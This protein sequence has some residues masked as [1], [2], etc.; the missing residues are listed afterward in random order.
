[1]T[2]MRGRRLTT[3]AVAG[4]LL[5]VAVVASAAATSSRDLAVA[6][7]QTLQTQIETLREIRI[8]R[9]ILLNKWIHHAEARLATLTAP[10]AARTLDQTGVRNQ[11]A[12]SR[13]AIKE[14]ASRKAALVEATRAR[15]A[16]LQSERQALAD[17]VATYGIF[18]ACPV[19][20]EHTVADNFGATVRLP[21]VP[22][23]VHQ[24][25]DIS[26]PSGTPIV[27]PFDGNAV[28]GR[29]EL[30]GLSVNVY[31]ELGHVYNAH[32]ASYGALGS[33]KAGDV[34]GYVG[35][36]GDATGPHNH[37]EWHPGDGAAVDPNEFL[38][39][40]C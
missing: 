27:A 9:V 1:M 30:G 14:L 5:A 39:A 19:A 37:F 32:L 17:W 3:L 36:T 8:H 2:R 34:I 22:V 31:N 10:S 7:R 35:T 4:C 38:A 15:V 13:S 21:G 23:H 25:N 33:V 28:A 24:G 11:A 26:S 29:S 40:V 20:G 16:K 6:K 18:E 12:K